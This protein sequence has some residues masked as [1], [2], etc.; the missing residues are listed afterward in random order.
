LYEEKEMNVKLPISHPSHSGSSPSRDHQ[1][2]SASTPIPL[3]SPINEDDGRSITDIFTTLDISS[4]ETVTGHGLHQKQT[5][6]SEEKVWSWIDHLSTLDAYS[7]D[8]EVDQAVETLH[9]LVKVFQKKLDR[10][11]KQNP[12]TS[13]IQLQKNGFPLFAKSILQSLC[14]VVRFSL[15]Q[16]ID[17]PFPL[18]NFTT[19]Q[20]PGICSK[21]VS[22]QPL[23][24]SN[25]LWALEQNQFAMQQVTHEP[26]SPTHSDKQERVLED[27]RRQY[28]GSGSH[29][30]RDHVHSIAATYHETKAYA[31]VLPILQS[32][33][34][35]K[36]RC[37]VELGKLELGLLVCIRGARFAD[38]QGAVSA[39]PRDE[40]VCEWLQSDTDNK[41]PEQ[42]MAAWLAATAYEI[43]QLC[44]SYLELDT[45]IAVPGE[46]PDRWNVLIAKIAEAL[47][48][49]DSQG[50]VRSA[51]SSLL[52]KIAATSEVIL[53]ELV[54]LIGQAETLHSSTSVT[55][56]T[57]QT[58]I[59]TLSERTC[60]IRAQRVAQE[61][62]DLEALFPDD[63]KAFFHLAIDEC[64][65]LGENVH[66][67]RRMWSDVSQKTKRSWILLLD[68]KFSISGISGV[69]A[70]N[71]SDRFLDGYTLPEPFM[72]L[73]LD[74]EL[75]D[76]SDT[77]DR[78]LKVINGQ[79]HIYT[80]HTVLEFLRK[81]GRPL[82]NDTGYYETKTILIQLL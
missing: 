36:T 70:Y 46:K 29:M 20:I 49:V 76:D 2:G 18:A 38:G 40:S 43:R 45:E 23:A 7:D 15:A 6:I 60:L 21:E 37:T 66:R 51:R 68:T 81:M 26:P 31:R 5:E 80:H 47:A 12:G 28:V 22:I 4:S 48:P 73:P 55:S 41:H 59:P 42:R 9:D 30:L 57:A 67:L 25:L 77:R 62:K 71:S 19:E 8:E 53:N 56:N 50:Q 34:S 27:F 74:V 13:T 32:S 16:D 10:L 17:P 44:T 82:L 24:L 39:P 14:E 54:T 1:D 64:S 61:F 3:G 78:Y 52:Q 75:A 63:S 72:L 35:G 33:G 58:K 79:D 11:R 69:V 65:Q